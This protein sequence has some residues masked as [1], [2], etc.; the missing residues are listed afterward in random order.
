VIHNALAFPPSGPVDQTARSAL[1]RAQGASETT[2]IL[3]NVAMFRPEKDHAALIEIAAQ[4]PREIDWQ[5]WLVGEGPTRE[6][7]AR[8]AALRGLGDRVRFLGFQN[9]PRPL[10]AAAD[11]AVLTSQRESLSNFLIEAHTHGLPSVAFDAL[12]VAECGGRVVPAGDVA[13]FRAVLEPWLT[14]PEARHTAGERAAVA[15]RDRFSPDTQ[16]AAYLELF[17]HLR[18]GRATCDTLSSTAGL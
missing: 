8:L 3:L 16:A 15:A 7:C 5:L 1:R 9:D 11:I 13:A 12:G 6:A 2:A 4:L 17:H 14:D 10:Y 18:H